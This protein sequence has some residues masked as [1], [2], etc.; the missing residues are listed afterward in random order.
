MTHPLRSKGPQ[1]ERRYGFF[2]LMSMVFLTLY[3]YSLYVMAYSESLNFITEIFFLGAIAFSLLNFIVTKEGFRLDYSFFSLLLFV[4]YAMMSAFWAPSQEG[5]TSLISTLIQ[6]FGLYILVRINIQDEKD[7]RVILWAL[8]IGTVIMC[9]YAVLY[10]GIAEIISR[11]SVG[12]RIGQ[13]INQSNGMGIYCTVLNILSLYFLMFEK[14]YWSIPVLV[15]SSFIMVGAGS[16]KSFL[17]MGMALLILFMFKTKRGVALRFMAVGVVLLVAVYLIIEFAD[18]EEHYFLYR[19]AQMFEILSDDQSAVT[20]DSLL[21]RSGMIRY[22]LELWSDNPV[23]GYGPEQYEYFYSLLYGVRRPPHST[24]I[25]ILVGFGGIGFTLF[26]GIY[27]F[28]YSKLIPMLKRQRKYSIL[29]LTFAVIFLVNDIGANML[30]NKYLYIFFA[31]YA[32]YISIK[33][34]DE[35]GEMTNEISDVGAE[36]PYQSGAHM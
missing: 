15:L 22:G 4:M 5:V 18:R 11:I 31:I 30:N 26:Y 21:T 34:N 3:I 12:N 29:I 6:L 19:I 27:A 28:V 32:G 25:Q 35:K 7:L 23:F 33:L 1:P 16:R 24:F 10:Y 36:I 14:H 8:Y 17:L 20:D 9:L 13:E 2:K